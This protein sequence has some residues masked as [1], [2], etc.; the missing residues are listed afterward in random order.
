[1]NTKIAKGT[2]LI[3]GA[4]G[5]LGNQLI[6]RL[7][8]ASGYKIIALTSQKHKLESKFK[9]KTNLHCF[10]L[11]D[12]R[13]GKLPFSTVDILINCAFARTSDGKDLASSL[14]FTNELISDAVTNG[15][16]SIINISSQ[17]VYSQKRKNSATEESTVVPESLYA[18]TK[19]STEMLI[20]TICKNTNVPYTH[21]RLGSLA[22]IGFDVRLT[23]RFIKNAMAGDPI[24]I[25]GGQQIISYMN[26]KDAADGIIALCSI[27]ANDWES[28]YNLGVEDFYTI[29]GVAGIVKRIATKYTSSPVNIEIENKDISFNISMDCNRFYEDVSWKPKYDME[30]IIEEQFKYLK[31]RSL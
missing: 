24:K 22:G 25:V 13:E 5:F 29:I 16:K 23:T 8:F 15:V 31:E 14:D 26:V 7:G 20:G 17:S 6:D 2:L 28:V 19:Y 11:E 12:W 18:M 21:I 9:G 30:S 27:D 3:T 4:G 10:D 1:M